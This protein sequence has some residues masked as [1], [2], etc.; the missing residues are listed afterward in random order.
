MQKHALVWLRPFTG[1]VP[2]ACPMDRLVTDSH[3]HS[4]TTTTPDHMG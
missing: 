3:H 4:R 2:V 1:A